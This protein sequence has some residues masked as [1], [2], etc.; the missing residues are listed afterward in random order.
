MVVGLLLG[1]LLAAGG[2]AD[3]GGLTA[4]ERQEYLD[5]HNELRGMV[6]PT[7]SNMKMMVGDE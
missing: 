7:A 5:K 1:L 4:D 3:E 2:R 6:A